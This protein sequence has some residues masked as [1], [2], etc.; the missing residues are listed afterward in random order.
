MCTRL[1]LSAGENRSATIAVLCDKLDELHAERGAW[2]DPLGTKPHNSKLVGKN[3]AGV[4]VLA[5]LVEQVASVVASAGQAPAAPS[6][7]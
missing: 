6:P 2:G 3:G 4:R 1:S 7:L 5:T